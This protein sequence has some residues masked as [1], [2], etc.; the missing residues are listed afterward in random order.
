MNRTMETEKC[1]MIEFGLLD[2][3]TWRY[4][5]Q[6]QNPSGFKVKDLREVQLTIIKC[7]LDMLIS[8]EW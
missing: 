1:N 4:L 8:K 3:A 6:L 2:D 7:L 5:L